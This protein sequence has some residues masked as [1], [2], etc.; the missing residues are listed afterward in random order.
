MSPSR[1]LRLALSLLR[2]DY[3]VG[4][5]KGMVQPERKVLSFSVCGC[6]MRMRFPSFRAQY[7]NIFV[8]REYD[9]ASETN[10]PIIVDLG[11]NVGMSCLFYKTRFPRCKIYAFE[12]DPE[13]FGLLQEN[14]ARNQLLENV[15][16][17]NKAAWVSDGRATFVPDGLGGGTMIAV[18]P[19]Q[20]GPGANPPA[21]AVKTV[22]TMDLK[23]W[24][25][26]HEF[27]FVKMDIES[28]ETAVIPHC[29]DE[30]CKAKRIVF[31]YHS[32]K[33]E[34]QML[35]TLLSLFAER[36]FRYHVKTEDTISNPFWSSC[37]GRYDNLVN[38]SLWRLSEG[39]PDS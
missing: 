14:L 6:R 23:P 15:Q 21:A 7:V 34:K 13:L 3:L 29:L 5:A 2:W 38:V 31:E 4:L 28:A 37:P 24:L 26:E 32:L 33:G 20:A 25:R 22:E 16:L 9:F 35:G 8:E 1:S 12:P 36:G 30:L 39:L 18:K 11:A 19:A 17:F 10:A 27:H